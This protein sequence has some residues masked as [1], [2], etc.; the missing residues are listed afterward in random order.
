MVVLGVV[1]T[2]PPL[3]LIDLS[4]NS[5]SVQLI[6]E[7]A[8]GILATWNGAA[9]DLQYPG[10]LLDY[11]ARVPGPFLGAN[12]SVQVFESAPGTLVV[13]VSRLGNVPGVDGSG[14]LVELELTPLAPG[15][16][17]L[18]FARNAALG[19]DGVEIQMGWGSGTV[20]VSP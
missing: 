6:T 20:S 18:A 17:P 8:P 4:P 19:A 11:Q 12:A 9:F 10:M 16:G 14:V 2:N 7:L 15:S 13:G 5:E 1:V 3:D